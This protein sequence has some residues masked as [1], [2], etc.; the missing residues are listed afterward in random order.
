M[1]ASVYD[2]EQTICNFESVTSFDALTIGP[3]TEHPL[4]QKVFQLPVEQQEV[5]QVLHHLLQNHACN[6]TLHLQFTMVVAAE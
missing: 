2:L 3:I 1:L 4:V 5:L 6:K